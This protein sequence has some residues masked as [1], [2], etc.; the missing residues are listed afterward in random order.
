MQGQLTVKPASL[1]TS[2]VSLS[3]WKLDLHGPSH[4]AKKKIK[5]AHTCVQVKLSLQ[6]QNNKKDIVIF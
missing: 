2:L 3:T 6:N 5:N 1:V 4:H